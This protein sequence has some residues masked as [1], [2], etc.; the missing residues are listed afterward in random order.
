MGR[1]EELVTGIRKVYKYSK[2]YSGKDEIEFT[3]Q[4]IPY[5][6]ESFNLNLV[7]IDIIMLYLL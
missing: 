4:N 2:A 3:L 5:Y 6:M 7:G 1:S